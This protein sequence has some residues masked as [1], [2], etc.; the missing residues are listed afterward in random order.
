MDS[1]FCPHCGSSNLHAHKKGYSGTAGFLGAVTFGVLGSFIGT[2]GSN[3]III[4]CLSCGRKY[5]PG[6]LSRTKLTNEQIVTNQNQSIS[7]FGIIWGIV[8]LIGFIWLLVTC[9]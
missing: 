7:W 6:Q 2:H 5:N 3:N 8:V 1:L 4:T 9:N